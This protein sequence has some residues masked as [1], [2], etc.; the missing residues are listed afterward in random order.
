MWNYLLILLILFLNLSFPHRDFTD[1]F[2]TENTE[3][4]DNTEKKLKNYI[5]VA[6]FAKL[7][8]LMTPE[9]VFGACCSSAFLIFFFSDYFSTF[10]GGKAFS[11]YTKKSYLFLSLFKFSLSLFS[12]FSLCLNSLFFSFPLCEINLFLGVLSDLGVKNLSVQGKVLRGILL[13]SGF[14]GGFFFISVRQ[15][16]MATSNCGSLP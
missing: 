14:S 3:N 2:N 13:K 15:V 9:S 4:T 5:R 8:A 11:G 7:L 12:S 10:F 16:L 6:I 1:E